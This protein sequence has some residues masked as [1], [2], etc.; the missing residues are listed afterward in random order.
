MPLAKPFSIFQKNGW[1]RTL[2][3]PVLVLHEGVSLLPSL[4]ILSQSMSGR[5]PIELLLPNDAAVFGEV[6][7]IVEEAVDYGRWVVLLN[8]HLA[9]ET[10]H[11]LASMALNTS[12]DD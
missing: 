5:A 9:P 4:R 11:R 7:R 2:S 3:K 1:R 12:A 8:A 6:E 10:M